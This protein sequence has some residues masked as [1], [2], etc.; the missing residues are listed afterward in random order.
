MPLAYALLALLTLFAGLCARERAMKGLVLLFIANWLFCKASYSE[1]PPVEVLW[2]MGFMLQSEGA[3]A[4]LDLVCASAAFGT[5]NRHWW[6]LVLWAS[7][8]FQCCY[9]VV[10]AWGLIEDGAYSDA[11]DAVFVLQAGVFLLVG[12]GGVRDHLDRLL[13]RLRRFR[14]VGRAA[15]LRAEQR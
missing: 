8:T 4:I 1:H 15:A 11:L 7:W 12:G 9:H 3:W 10:A 2:Q 14:G 13:D 5:A 6:G